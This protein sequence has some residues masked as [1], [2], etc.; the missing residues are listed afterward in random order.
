MTDTSANLPAI[1]ERFAILTKKLRSSTDPEY[2]RALLREFRVLIA[3]ADKILREE[4][5]N[6]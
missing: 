6:A 4:T 3:E 5:P 2:R 1:A